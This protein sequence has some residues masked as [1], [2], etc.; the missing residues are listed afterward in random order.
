[1]QCAQLFLQFLTFPIHRSLLLKHDWQPTYAANRT[2]SILHYAASTHVHLF[3]IP[4]Y[5]SWC[6]L[7]VH[8][9]WL[10]AS[11]VH[12]NVCDFHYLRENIYIFFRCIYWPE[13]G[14]CLPIF[15]AFSILLH[16]HYGFHTYVKTFAISI[17]YAKIFTFSLHAKKNSIITVVT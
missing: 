1:V 7:N 11:D 16:V 9:A 10:M 4:T 2:P 13:L 6:E 3:C 15:G 5:V 17:I 12:Q 8:P 14:N